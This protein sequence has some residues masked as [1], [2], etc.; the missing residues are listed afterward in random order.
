[1][2]ML[3][4]R[5]ACLVSA[6]SL[7]LGLAACNPA[8]EPNAKKTEAPPAEAGMA[9]MTPTPFSS[10]EHTMHQAMMAATGA[11]P[12]DA[13]ARKM[14][15]HHQGTL[16]MSQ[17]VLRESQDSDIRRM[18][19]KTIDMQTKD[20]ADL[21]RWLEGRPAGSGA[22]N[23]GAVF[24]DAESRMDAAMMAVTG[25]DPAQLWAGKMVAHHQGAL[26]MSALVLRTAQDAGIRRMAQATLDMQ[27]KDIAEMRAWLDAHGAAT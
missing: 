26:D 17:V 9:T 5:H 15:P 7:V 4:G 19:Q 18:A 16:D 11:T 2:I 23:G 27:T 1:M 22:G 10:V 20:I 21:R 12:E 25:S 8:A 13:W 3:T 6:S 24:R 14:I